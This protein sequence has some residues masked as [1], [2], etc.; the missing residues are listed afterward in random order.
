MRRK[1]N[2]RKNV[3]LFLSVLLTLCFS[4]TV[5]AEEESIPI[6]KMHEL[7]KHEC[8][9]WEEGITDSYGNTYKDN[10]ISVNGGLDGNAEFMQFPELCLPDFKRC[11][12][13]CSRNPGISLQQFQDWIY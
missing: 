2:I 10:V 12:S 1:K 11:Y 4:C 3:V 9:I 8:Y 6:S 13:S 7:D 5:Q